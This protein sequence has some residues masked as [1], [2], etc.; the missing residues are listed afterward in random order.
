[1]KK[2]TK[3]VATIG[4][5]SEA[6]ETLEAMINAGMNVARFN[7]KHN[8]PEW[9]HERMQ[10]VRT[11][12]ERLGV[13][14]ANLIDLQGPEIRSELAG[15][16]D[17]FPVEPGNVVTFTSDEAAAAGR[18]R[19][20]VVPEAMIKALSVGNKILIE[21][22]IGEFMV[23]AVSD[24]LAE[25]TV[26]QSFIVKKR[27]TLNMPGV[28][29]ELP[30]LI[31]TDF[32]HINA[33]RNELV[34]YFAL[35]FVR[36]AHDI[37]LLRAELDKRGLTAGI[38]AKIE[39]QS[40]IDHLDS[41]IAASDAVMVARGDLGVEVP[42]QELSHWQKVIIQKSRELGK[43]VITA[44]QMLKSMTDSPLPSRAEV[45]DVSNAVYDGTDAVMLSE[46][47]TIGK[48]PVKV[49][50]TQA[51]IC[52]YTEKFATPPSITAIHGDP[53]SYITH[54]AMAVLRESSENEKISK[55]VCLT[56]TGA[57]ARHLARFRQRP[58]IHALTHNV[59]TY[60][61]LALLYG[62][63][64][65]RTDF[66]SQELIHS[67][68]IQKIIELGIAVRGETVMIIHGSYWKNPGRTNTLKVVE[69]P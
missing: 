52:E 34:D 11:V 61:K 9:H 49:V 7:T 46:E 59:Q 14:V 47:T 36:N 3:V 24:K 57:T 2:R 17:S 68:V 29:V 40:A 55:I 30:S 67:E 22:G 32:I 6:I 5:A 23:T 50:E 12:A 39:N 65:H 27:K 21:D 41:I 38:V 48:Y 45:S 1:M 19:V 18:E 37:E 64:A 53:A 8:E 66:I 33:A 16:A 69:I 13:P 58:I 56:E 62:V 60:N 20:V 10:R 42:F 15:G 31:D 35:S 28:D 25:A 51:S 26:H 63:E 4:P 44:T 54:A 43:P